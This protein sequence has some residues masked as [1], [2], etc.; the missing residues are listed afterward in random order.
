MG[1]G[2][3]DMFIGIVY[4]YVVYGEYVVVFGVGYLCWGDCFEYV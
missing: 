2:Y 4:V 3:L 1:I